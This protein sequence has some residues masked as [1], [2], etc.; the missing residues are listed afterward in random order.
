MAIIEHD[1]HPD[2]NIY[3]VMRIFGSSLLA[4]DNIKEL[5]SKVPLDNVGN[6]DM[7]NIQLDIQFAND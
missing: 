7:L 1:L 4:K 3:E 6:N 5:C 2:C